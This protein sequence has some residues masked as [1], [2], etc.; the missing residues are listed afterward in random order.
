M[1]DLQ[2]DCIGDY[3]SVGLK[4]FREVDRDDVTTN[5][6]YNGSLEIFRYCEGREKEG[7]E[8]REMER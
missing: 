1:C 5:G 8:E 7:N 3:D 2:E 4:W 6:F